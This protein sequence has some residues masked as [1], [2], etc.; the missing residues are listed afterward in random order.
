[1]LTTYLSSKEPMI[2]L[3]AVCESAVGSPDKSWRF[4]LPYREPAIIVEEMEQGIAK[5]VR[6]HD[7]CC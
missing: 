4:T 2:I 7:D 5:G 6:K 3:K 1:M